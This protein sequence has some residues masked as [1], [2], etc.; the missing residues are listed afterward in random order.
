MRVQKEA[1]G[2]TSRGRS[3]GK[4]LNVKEPNHE[5]HGG[6]KEDFMVPGP[7]VLRE[8]MRR[9]FPVWNDKTVFT[10]SNCRHFQEPVNLVKLLPSRTLPVGLLV[11]QSG[12]VSLRS[13]IAG[14]NT[15]PLYKSFS[16]FQLYSQI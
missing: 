1:A 14:N 9:A 8:S 6:R 7:A 16:K 13:I 10:Q 2:N 12:N 4:A 11:K 3:L 15:A 5:V